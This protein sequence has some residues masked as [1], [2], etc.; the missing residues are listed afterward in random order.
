MAAA[1]T[2]LWVGYLSDRRQVC[3][4]SVSKWRRESPDDGHDGTCKFANENM[5]IVVS[6]K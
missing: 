1:M 4:F 2:Q 5:A 6:N 3:F